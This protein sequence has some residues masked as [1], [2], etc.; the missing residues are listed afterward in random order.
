MGPLSLQIP[1]PTRRSSSCHAVAE[2]ADLAGGESLVPH[3]IVQVLADLA[4]V[5]HRAVDVADLQREPNEFVPVDERNDV[6]AN[7][8]AGVP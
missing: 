8:H 2:Q 4:F 5:A 3:P 7:G 1:S 6:V